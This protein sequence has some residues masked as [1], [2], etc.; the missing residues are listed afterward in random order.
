MT[1]SKKYASNEKTQGVEYTYG[2][3]RVLWVWGFRG[4]SN[5]FFCVC[6]R[7]VIGIE[8]KYHGSPARA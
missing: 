5:R 1:N 6:V 7:W 8:I 3:F 2:G 4:D